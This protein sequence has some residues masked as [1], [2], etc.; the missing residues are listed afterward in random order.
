MTNPKYKFFQDELESWELE[1]YG[2]GKYVQPHW[3]TEELKDCADRIAKE[4]EAR[5]F[6]LM[7]V[8]GFG[9]AY[10]KP[11]HCKAAYVGTF[12]N[13][14]TKGNGKV[15]LYQDQFYITKKY[16][17]IEEVNRHNGTANNATIRISVDWMDSDRTPE[18]KTYNTSAD[19]TGEDY[20][21]VIGL[22]CMQKSKE[23]RKIRPTISDKVLNKVLDQAETELDNI[24]IHDPSSYEKNAEDYPKSTFKEWKI[25][26]GI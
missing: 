14:Y 21:T 4:L 1:K 10:A 9:Y 6:R 24:S 25:S 19:H 26:R 3:S 11:E 23:I 20:E 13:P 5:G 22:P 17:G 12:V 7:R 2:D 8:S 15:T 16:I 18:Y